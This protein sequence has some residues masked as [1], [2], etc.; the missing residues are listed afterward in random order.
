[1]PISG[2]ENIPPSK[3]QNIYG[4]AVVWNLDQSQ[5]GYFTNG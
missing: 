2:L 1:M 5:K 3:K 4:F